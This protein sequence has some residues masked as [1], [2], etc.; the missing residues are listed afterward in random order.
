MTIYA[1]KQEEICISTAPTSLVV[2]GYVRNTIPGQSQ[3][4]AK[5]LISENSEMTM[6]SYESQSIS[7][8]IGFAYKYERRVPY[9]I[10]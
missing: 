9:A 5:I 8:E 3:L 2:P 4:A 7:I 10:Y 1:E 6:L